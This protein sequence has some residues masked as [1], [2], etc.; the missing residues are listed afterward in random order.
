MSERET[1]RLYANAARRYDRLT[2]L[3]SFG[4]GPWYRR[5][6]VNS[7]K[8]PFGG[9]ALDLGS[10]TGGLALAMQ[11]SM[12][13]DA[14]VIAMD[15]SAEMLS[16]ARRCGVRDTLE[17]SMNDIPL[18]D[19]SMDGV[20]CGYAIRYATDLSKTLK[21]IRRVLKPGAPVVLLEMTIPASTIGKTMASLM[22]RRVS[23][24]AMTV[25]CASRGVG[26]LMRHFWDSV[27]TFPPPEKVVGLL[28]DV[29][30]NRIRKHG[31]WGM[32]VE[33]RANA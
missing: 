27:S 33:Y 29:G 4:S 12:G 17:G 30:F 19:N 18:A 28:E 25:C 15:T 31:P 6:V 9:T 1:V 32:L 24:A 3:M 20:V 5:R 11:D 13:D 14:R 16:E 26:D 21:E 8:M 2:G 22:I 23:P 10:G 7:M